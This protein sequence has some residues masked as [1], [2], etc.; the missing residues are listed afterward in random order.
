ME[1]LKKLQL[2]I[3]AILTI[4]V[5]FLLF[6][7]KR[8]T[9]ENQNLKK[10][11]KELKAKI[12]DKDN[13]I[14]SLQESAKYDSIA[15]YEGKRLLAKSEAQKQAQYRQASKDRQ[16]LSGQLAEARNTADSLQSYI[17]AYDTLQRHYNNLVDLMQSREIEWKNIVA[18]YD[19]LVSNKNA[20]IATL[21]QKNDLIQQ[22]ADN[23][24]QMYKNAKKQRNISRLEKWL[25]GGAVVA[26]LILK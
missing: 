14:D 6:Q 21:N 12:G 19:T 15:I 7:P 1:T 25:L 16:T 17:T 26:I 13:V 2:P 5:I 23:W 18:N 11:V 9:I 3:I 24:E 20:Q 4:L 10:E 8:A 22:T